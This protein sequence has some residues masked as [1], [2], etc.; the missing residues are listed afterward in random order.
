MP[1]LVPLNL[2]YPSASQSFPTFP[3]HSYPT[4]YDHGK[5][6]VFSSPSHTLL[7][8]IILNLTFLLIIHNWIPQTLLMIHQIHQ[9]LFLLE[10]L[11][12]TEPDQ[13]SFKTFTLYLHQLLLV[14]PQV[15]VIL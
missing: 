10:D 3:M 12:G 9:L 4:I 5:D 13:R 14:N 1:F 11:I 15:F 6:L 7:S 8:L 2:F